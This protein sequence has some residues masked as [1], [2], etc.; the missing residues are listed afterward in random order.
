ME[1]K[2]K[3]SLFIFHRDLR[4]DDNTGLIEALKTSDIVIPCFIFDTTTII[5]KDVPP[6]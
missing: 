1:K 2:F 6:K 4:L 5:N 3:K